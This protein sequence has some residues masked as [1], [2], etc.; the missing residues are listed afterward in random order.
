MYIPTYVRIFLVC[1]YNSYTE[2]YACLRSY[3][4]I[5]YCNLPHLIYSPSSVPSSK[6]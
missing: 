6:A 2:M 5:S 4:D 1:S 3:V